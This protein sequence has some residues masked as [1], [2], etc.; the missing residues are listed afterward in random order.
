ME[1]MGVKRKIRKR[2]PTRWTWGTHSDASL[3]GTTNTIFIILMC[4]N[5]ICVENVSLQIYR[6]PKFLKIG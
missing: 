1:V 5:I 6:T 2:L 3:V 4:H